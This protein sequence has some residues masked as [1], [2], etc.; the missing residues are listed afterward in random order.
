MN[1]ANCYLRKK[2]TVFKSLI[3]NKPQNNYFHSVEM[4]L[5][6]E[7]GGEV[8]YAEFEFVIGQTIERVQIVQKHSFLTNLIE[9]TENGN[10]LNKMANDIKSVLEKIYVGKPRD[11]FIGNDFLISLDRFDELEDIIV[12]KAQLKI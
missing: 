12:T 4:F 2:T 9:A 7:E 6:K 10:A 5:T 1:F 11:Y 8:T 3:K